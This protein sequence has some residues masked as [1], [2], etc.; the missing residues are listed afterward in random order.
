MTAPPRPAGAR[1]I[2]EILAA[3]RHRLHRLDPAEAHA[4]FTAGALLVDIRPQAHRAAEGE[5]PGSLVVERNVLEWRLD[6]ASDARLPQATGYDLRVIVLC[7]E[8]Y[9]SSL[10]AASLH[11]LGLRR[12]TDVAGGYRAWRAAGLPT[13]GSP[14]PAA[15]DP[16]YH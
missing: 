4:E 1:S 11:D 12:A 16:T 15:P 7:S 8:G 5:V 3:A 9:T 2:D 10:A 6:P 13:T 14:W